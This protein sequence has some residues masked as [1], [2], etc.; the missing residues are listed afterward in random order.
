M[1]MPADKSSSGEAKGAIVNLQRQQ[2][3]SS[4]SLS[5]KSRVRL[6]TTKKMLGPS[7]GHTCTGLGSCVVQAP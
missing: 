1:N 2:P 3:V 4:S 6:G 7:V 5:C